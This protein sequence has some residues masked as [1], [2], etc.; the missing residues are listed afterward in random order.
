MVGQ[1]IANNALRDYA[2]NPGF[3][4]IV[5]MVGINDPDSIKTIEFKGEDFLQAKT[6][7]LSQLNHLLSKVDT[8]TEEGVMLTSKVDKLT[9]EFVMLTRQVGALME[10]VVMLTREVENLTERSKT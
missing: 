2:K 3:Q 9:E 8:L 1:E 6:T 7:L 5:D 10:K 4:S